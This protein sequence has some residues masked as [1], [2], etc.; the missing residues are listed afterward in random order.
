[1]LALATALPAQADPALARARNCL[2][3]HALEGKVIGPGFREVA[4]RYAGQADAADK[5]A[6]K[7]VKGGAGSWGVVQM[8]AN[9]QVSEAEARRLALW[10]L[11]R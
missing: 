10:I 9:P 4:R 8:P 11:G 2:T 3:C 7:I 5:L 1:M 6:V